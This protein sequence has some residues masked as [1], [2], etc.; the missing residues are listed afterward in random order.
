MME[1]SKNPFPGLPIQVT[2]SARTP[3]IAPPDGPQPFRVTP[4]QAQRLSQRQ[5]WLNGVRGRQ[6]AFATRAPA[7]MRRPELST[8]DFLNDHYVPMVPVVIP[9]VAAD[10]PAIGWTP[11]RLVEIVG[12]APVTFQAARKADPQFELMKDAHKRTAPFPEFMAAITASC[13]NDA[14]LTAYNSDTNRAALAPLERDLGFLDAYLTRQHGMPWIGPAGTFTP[15]HHDLTHNLL[16]QIV[17]RKRILL[18]SPSATPLLANERHVFSEVHDLESEA[19]LARHPQARAV[20]R[21]EV[22]LHPGDALFIPVGWWHQVTSLDF[23]VT[24]TCTNFHWPND[25][26]ATFPAL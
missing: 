9:G 17:G 18:V 4:Q 6:Q 7:I 11:E 23:S 16:V 5:A 14:Y 19:H 10:W 24:Y 8:D 2:G 26:F 20:I 15:L 25:A 22:I 12:D 21:H 3:P 13:G 1:P